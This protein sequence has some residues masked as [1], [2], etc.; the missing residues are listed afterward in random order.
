MSRQFLQKKPLYCFL[1]SCSILKGNT[2]VNYVNYR[3]KLLDI[4]C[5]KIFSLKHFYI[6]DEFDTFVYSDIE[7]VGGFEVI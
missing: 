7:K 5:S 4:F 3:S 6:S 2:D 1:F